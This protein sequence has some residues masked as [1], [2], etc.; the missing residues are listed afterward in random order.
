VNV[1]IISEHDV[2]SEIF[3]K[4]Q[5]TSINLGPLTNQNNP[6]DRVMIIINHKLIC[7]YDILSGKLIFK[8]MS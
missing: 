6:F 8:S 4:F 1:I 5:I 3:S 7:I 2:E